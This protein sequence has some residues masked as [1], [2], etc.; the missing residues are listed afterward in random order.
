MVVKEIKATILGNVFE[1]KIN[2]KTIKNYT[3][4]FKKLIKNIKTSEMA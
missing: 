2:T 3:K 4:T 1:E